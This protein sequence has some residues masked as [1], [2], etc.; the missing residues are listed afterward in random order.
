[1][2]LTIA[3][4]REQAKAV[5]VAPFPEESSSSPCITSLTLHAHAFCKPSAS[6]KG[7]RGMHRSDKFANHHTRAD[8]LEFS[9]ISSQGKHLDI[10]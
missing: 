4:A 7:N 5:P 10:Y 1:M 8:W 2:H 9:D 3:T 6:G